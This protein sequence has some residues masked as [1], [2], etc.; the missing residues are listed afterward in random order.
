MSYKDK[1]LLRKLAPHEHKGD[2]IEIIYLESHKAFDRFTCRVSH[3]GITGMGCFILHW[4]LSQKLKTI[5]GL[6]S[7]N[8]LVLVILQPVTPRWV[9]PRIQN[10]LS[11]SANSISLLLLNTFKGFHC[12]RSALE[13][14]MLHVGFSASLAARTHPHHLSSA[15]PMPGFRSKWWG[16]YDYVG[17]LASGCV[18]NKLEFLG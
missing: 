2:L 11:R 1:E 8:S 7:Y 15:T 18:C 6:K 16:K 13:L 12:F 17:T 9:P 10:D 4:E 5:S 14:N 3:P